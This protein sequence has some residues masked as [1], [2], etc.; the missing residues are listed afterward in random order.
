MTT[1]NEDLLA[2]DSTQKRELVRRLLRERSTRDSKRRLSYGE[3]GI[4]LHNRLV[5]NSSSYN[6]LYIGRVHGQLDEQRLELALASLATRHEELVVTFDESAGEPVAISH[7]G[8]TIPSSWIDASDWDAQQIQQW[9]DEKLDAPID[10]TAG[11]VCAVTVL[12]V[13]PDHQLIAVAMSHIVMDFWS[14]DILLAELMAFYGEPARQL[15]SPSARYAD[16][17][18]WQEELLAGQKGHL[19]WDYW[20]EQ[21]DGDRQRLELPGKRPRPSNQTFVGAT[22]HFDID[23]T[24]TERIRELARV[25]G[26][27]LQVAVL[28]AFFAVLH[29][30]SGLDDIAVGSPIAGRGMPGAEATVGYFINP[31]VIRSTV[32][33]DPSFTELLARTRRTVL[34]AIEHEDFPIA[35]LAERLEAT[36]DPAY[37]PLYQTVF[38]WETSRVS[39]GSVGSTTLGGLTLETISLRQGGAPVDLML[40]VAEREHNL[41][42][43]FQYNTDLF[44][45]ATVRRLAG[46]L[47]T[48]LSGAT[49][50]PTAQIGLIPLMTDNELSEVRRWNDTEVSAFQGCRLQDLVEEQVT[51]TPDAPAVT[52]R[53]RT[54]SYNEMY[55]RATDLAG[56]ICPLA[57]PGSIVGI[58]IERSEM[59]VIAVLAIL[60]AECTFLPVD[61]WHPVERLRSID[62]ESAPAVWIT[63]TRVRKQLPE[64][65]RVLDLDALGA[66][67]VCVAEPRPPRSPDDIAYVMFTSGSTGKPK[68]ASNTHRGIANRLLWGQNAYPLTAQDVVLHKTPANFDVSLWELFWALIAGARLV[69]AEPGKHSDSAY[70]IDAINSEGV[71]VAHFVPSMLRAFLSDPGAGSCTSLRHVITSGEA[72]TADLRDHFFATVPAELHNLYGPTEA[73]VEAT[74]FDCVRGDDDPLVPIGRPIANVTTHLLDGNMLPVPIGVLG[75]LY[76]GGIGVATGYLNRPELT[77]ERFVDSAHGRL[78][79]TGDFGRYRPDGN[80]EY[81]GRADDQIKIRGVRIELGEVEAALAA[82]P[83]VRQ[84][85]VVAGTDHTGVPILVAY[86]VAADPQSAPSPIAVREFVRQTLPD[87]MLP[88]HI[89]VVDDIPTTSSGKRDL[90]ALPEPDTSRPDLTAEFVAPRDDTERAIADIWRRTLQLDAVGVF[91]DF[92]DLGGSSSQIMTFCAEARAMDLAVTAELVF[93]HRTVAEI[94]AAVDAVGPPDSVEPDRLVEPAEVVA[95]PTSQPVRIGVDDDAIVGNTVIESIGVYLP[96]AELTTKEI[97]SGCERKVEVPLEEL[98]G[99]RSRRVVADGEFTID[100]AAEAARKCFDRSRHS[101]TSIDLLICTNISRVEGP[102]GRLVLEPSMSLQLREIL[103]MDNALSFDVSNACAGMFTGISIAD[104]FFATGR[105]RTAMVVSGEYV[106]HI[107]G[108]AQ[109]EITEFLDERLACLTVGDAGAAVI[110]E[111]GA[112]PSVGFRDLRLRSL[113]RYSDLCIAKPSEDSRGGAI[114]RTKAVE[115]TAIAVRKA[116]PFAMRMLEAHGWLPEVVDHF[117]VHQTSRSSITDAM[118]TVNGLFGRSVANEVNTVCNLQERGNTASTTHFVAIEDLV[119]N[120]SIQQG[121]RMLFGITGSGQTIGA[122]LYTFDDLPDR[123]RGISSAK[124][125]A[126]PVRHDRRPTAPSVSIDAVGVSSATGPE[127]A[128]ALATRAAALCIGSGS[129]DKRDIGIVLYAG[130]FRDDCVVEPAMATFV[131]DGLRINDDP[132]EPFDGGTFAYDVRDGDVGFLKACHISCVGIESGATENAMV[133]TAEID[134]DVAHGST[135]SEGMWHTGSA[136]LLTKSDAGTG[137]GTFHFK[138]HPEY[139]DAATSYSPMTEGGRLHVHRL[140]GIEDVYLELISD[141]VAEFIDI[142]DFRLDDIDVVIAPQI[143]S[144]FLAALAARL[145][146]SRSVVIDVVDGGSDLHTS[147]IPAAIQYCREKSVVSRGQVGLLIAAGAG[148]QIGCAT[149]YF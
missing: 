120:G 27:T 46:H 51:R 84:A 53:D 34:G 127:T 36:R 24:L 47:G 12:D 3:R 114:M 7:P 23:A 66:E 108:T 69:V 142:A 121:D 68:G 31:V 19:L 100:L 145:N 90:K 4:W 11:P 91:D 28:S 137:F 58:A 97:L 79:R 70:L 42:A 81:G 20:R 83:D 45:E 57:P 131:A 64:G 9:L 101:A 61:P 49:A 82:S 62:E 113:S 98:T 85:V 74:Y 10:L 102:D 59:S 54:V 117:L 112:D 77:A 22:H 103:G 132:A 72:L 63:E 118:N 26:V 67:P 88:T 87:A 41:S 148:V 55:R 109:R 35:L 39:T 78:Y 52:F 110:L 44:D 76:L 138:T 144:H 107:I 143:S 123:M 116:V 99:I 16:Y 104:Y 38:A 2:L 65:V 122:S 43:I 95:A 136:L 128:R 71:T 14:L 33:D 25:E 29:R 140:P 134:T 124:P 149:Y 37:P 40:L 93:R 129:V 60:L 130:V 126:S 86:V 119:Q 106:S 111:R 6:M 96:A 115:Q 13:A 32:S 133:V 73:S 139:L 56:R 125:A 18:R 141:A 75:E 146:V 21:L 147:S 15:S 80:I 1:D 17:V 135:A 92:F 94:A 30:D 8:A 105:I 5:P 48:F 89:V 50:D